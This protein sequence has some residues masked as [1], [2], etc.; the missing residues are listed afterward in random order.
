MIKMEIVLVKVTMS[1]KVEVPYSDDSWDEVRGQLPDGGT[2][3]IVGDVKFTVD[4]AEIVKTE[5]V[6]ET[7][8]Y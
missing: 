5:M 7:Q 6:Y 8:E 3:V 1:A 4:D 2:E